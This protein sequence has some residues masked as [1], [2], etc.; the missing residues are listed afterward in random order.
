MKIAAHTDCKT[1]ASICTHVRDGMPRKATVNMGGGV[2]EQGERR[3]RN[4]LPLYFQKVSETV[5]GSC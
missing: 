5:A 1:T 2:W 3:V 4:H